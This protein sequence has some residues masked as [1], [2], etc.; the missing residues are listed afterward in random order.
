MHPL[1]PSLLLIP[2]LFAALPQGQEPSAAALQRAAELARPATAHQRLQRLVGRWNVAVAT[3]LAA[4]AGPATAETGAMV[5]SAL[6]GGRYVQL[7][8]ELQSVGGA[9][10][11]LQLLGFDNLHQLYTSSWRD[12]RSTWSVECAGAPVAA[13]PD[14]LVLYGT[15]ADARDPEGRAFRLE[16]DL[17]DER[18]DV[19]LYDTVAGE[20]TLRQTQRWTRA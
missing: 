9:F 1:R 16:F 20:P 18:V 4:D 3:V 13:A 12:E 5:A 2:M 7:Q 19:R 6:L 10:A 8:F 14:R 17:A 15:L 11:G